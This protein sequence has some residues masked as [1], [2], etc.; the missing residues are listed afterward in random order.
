MN[1]SSEIQAVDIVPAVT[2]IVQ[3]S[4][5]KPW[6]FLSGEARPLATWLETAAVDPTSPVKTV[7]NN[8]LTTGQTV[9]EV[10]REFLMAIRGGLGFLSW[11]TIRDL[12]TTV[13]SEAKIFLVV[14]Y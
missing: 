12:E 11:E 9:Y 5:G 10:D 8:F 3:C 6:G 2:L 4:D 1:Q 14:S 7:A 13:P